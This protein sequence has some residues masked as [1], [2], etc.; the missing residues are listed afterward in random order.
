MEMQVTV[1]PS[2]IALDTTCTVGLVGEGVGPGGREGV[3]SRDFK[4]T[5]TGTLKVVLEVG[6]LKGEACLGAEGGLEG[7]SAGD[8]PGRIAPAG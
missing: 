3:L 1:W 7:G 5:P 2:S 4:G 6:V 8:S